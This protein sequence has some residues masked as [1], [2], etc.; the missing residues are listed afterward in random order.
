MCSDKFKTFNWKFLKLK[1]VQLKLFQA[2]LKCDVH[3]GHA[4]SLS[5]CKVFFTEIEKN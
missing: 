1:T 3:K 5:I 2:Q 4:L